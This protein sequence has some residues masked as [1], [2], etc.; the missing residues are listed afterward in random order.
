VQFSF[1]GGGVGGTPGLGAY[2]A[3]KFAVDGLTRVLAMKTAPFGIRYLTVEPRGFYTNGAGASREIQ[4]IPPYDATVGSLARVLKTDLVRTG[5]PRRAAEILVRVVKRQNLPTHL[6]LGSAAVYLARDNP[7]T[8]LPSWRPGERLVS[9]RI[10]ISH[11][12]P[13]CRTTRLHR[14]PL[15]IFA[16]SGLASH[17]PAVGIVGIYEIHIGIQELQTNAANEWII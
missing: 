4:S 8:R 10:S 3:A 15:N 12:R 7:P 13:E 2:Q 16:E 14:V 1:V 17:A 6:V 5:D 11:I 9:R